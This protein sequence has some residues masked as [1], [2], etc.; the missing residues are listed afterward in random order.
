MNSLRR[1]QPIQTEASGGTL[2]GGSPGSSPRRGATLT[3]VLMSILI[4]S[5]GLVSVVALF[6][7]ATFRSIRATQLTQAAI[8]KRN[9]ETVLAYAQEVGQGAVAPQTFPWFSPNPLYD[10]RLNGL[11]NSPRMVFDPLGWHL[12]G[13]ANFADG[14]KKANDADLDFAPILRLNGGTEFDPA[15]GNPLTV[16]VAERNAAYR[17]ASGD[18]WINVI[19]AN[20]VTYTAGAL[21]AV[22]DGASTSGI[23]TAAGN[24]LSRVIFF[25]I[26]GKLSHTRPIRTISAGNV[27]DWNEAADTTDRDGNGTFAGPLPAGFVP[28]YAR[29]QTQDRRYTWL[30][31]L[32]VPGRYVHVAV[33]F[34]RTFGPEDELVYDCYP[35]AAEDLDSDGILDAGEDKN[36]NG[37]L[38]A[39]QLDFGDATGSTFNNFA[40]AAVAPGLPQ[41]VKKNSYVLDAAN[42][43]WYRVQTVNGTRITITTL[44]GRPSD[45]LRF[46]IFMRGIVDVYPMKASAEL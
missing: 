14:F 9:A 12:V 35:T 36:G 27:V 21:T 22:I 24:P 23:T 7:L 42:L 33:F 29:L 37:V 41:F 39:V 30:M 46:A 44:D 2:R 11:G 3:E 18:T 38:D 25:D 32:P 34:N 43:E 8:L 28:A 5:V 10:P 20:Q 16:S 15:P 31:T 13:Q 45:D 40:G 1:Q 6:P 17:L 19:E 4:M 26:T